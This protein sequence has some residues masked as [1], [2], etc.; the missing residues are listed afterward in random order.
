MW[1]KTGG[2]KIWELE[3]GWGEMQGARSESGLLFKKEKFYIL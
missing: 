3:F 2:A 1:F